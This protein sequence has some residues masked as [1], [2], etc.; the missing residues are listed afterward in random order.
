M[1]NDHQHTPGWQKRKLLFLIFIPALFFVMAAAVQF[2][3]NAIL[4]DL[5]HAGIISYW[6]AMGL[7]ALSRILFGGFGFH[8]RGGKPHFG[9][10]SP[11]KEKWMG[12]NDEE[13]QK[14]RDEWKS[15]CEH[16]NH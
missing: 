1:F 5:V 14:F 12:M 6:Q 15:R 9:H 10:A 8:G 11:L 2:L 13:K 3:W 7:L 4:P 16:R